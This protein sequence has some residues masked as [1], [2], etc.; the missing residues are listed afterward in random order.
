[1]GEREVLNKYYPLSFDPK[2]TPR[3]RRPKNHQKKIR[4]MLPVS[5]RCNTCGNYMSKG[6]KFNSREEEVIGEAYLGIKIHRFYLKCTNCSAEV[7]IKTDPKNTGYTVESGATCPRGHEE[8]E[9]EE[10]EKHKGT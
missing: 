2:K 7:T 1:M 10:E 9:E 6:T 5:V 3:L 8:E 4:F